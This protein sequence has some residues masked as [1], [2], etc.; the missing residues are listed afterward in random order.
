M[1]YAGLMIGA[2]TVIA[3]VTFFIPIWG[4]HYWFH[5]PQKTITSAEVSNITVIPSNGK[6][7]RARIMA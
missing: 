2:I 1:N 7:A 5:G 6:G 3:I 4:G